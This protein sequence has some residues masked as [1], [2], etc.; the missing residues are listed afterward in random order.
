MSELVVSVPVG[1]PHV[2]IEFYETVVSKRLVRGFDE[3]L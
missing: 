2:M 1:S 3:I